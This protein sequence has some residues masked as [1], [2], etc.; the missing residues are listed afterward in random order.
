[1]DDGN[2]PYMAD[3]DSDDGS[4]D[5]NGVLVLPTRT[6]IIDS[7]SSRIRKG[8]PHDTDHQFTMFELPVL[9]ATIPN[10]CSTKRFF[11]N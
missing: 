7:R 1:M 10:H 5:S 2:K 11:K 4:S 9:M 6:R 8:D 3:V